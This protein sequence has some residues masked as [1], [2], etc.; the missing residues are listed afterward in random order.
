MV[1]TKRL[2]GD[3]GRE[4]ARGVRVVNVA[5]EVHAVTHRD[6]DILFFLDLIVN[7]LGD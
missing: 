3:Q 5:S 7:G 2:K 4:F 6:G 1:F